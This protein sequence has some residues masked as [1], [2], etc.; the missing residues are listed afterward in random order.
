MKFEEYVPES[1]KIG[2]KV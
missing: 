1:L 2:E